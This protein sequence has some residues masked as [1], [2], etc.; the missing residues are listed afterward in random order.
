VGVFIDVIAAPYCYEASAAA[1]AKEWSKAIVGY[2]IGIPLALIGLSTVA[3]ALEVLPPS[4]VSSI[5]LYVQPLATD[6]RWWLLI[7]FIVL[8]WLGGPRFVERM[9]T[10]WNAKPQE[11]KYDIR[12]LAMPVMPKKQTPSPEKVEAIRA[13]ASVLDSR[14]VGEEAPKSIVAQSA[15]AKPPIQMK[16]RAKLSKE[17][18]RTIAMAREI[19]RESAEHEAAR[20]A[21]NA[22]SPT[23]PMT[24]LEEK[25]WLRLDVLFGVRVETVDSQERRYLTLKFLPDRNPQDAFSLLLI[26]YG[27]RQIYGWQDVRASGLEE[28]L[29]LSNVR[30]K[31]TTMDMIFGRSTI[32]DTHADRLNVDDV[33]KASALRNLMSEKIHLAKGG[34]YELTE[35]GIKT[36]QDLFTDLVRRS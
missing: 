4:A 18:E 21:F 13:M 32:F 29:Y 1:M 34:F 7:W 26:L 12:E 30:K 14:P 16:P 11:R 17:A 6:A 19:D 5:A 35:T 23:R 10:A 9:R 36:A 15:E 8:V 25:E 27:Y 28:S 2:A 20:R 31:Q 24:D 3:I 33:A 22:F